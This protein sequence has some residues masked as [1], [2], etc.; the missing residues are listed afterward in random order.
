MK[1]PCNFKL[2]TAM[3]EKKIPQTVF[4]RKWLLVAID[5]AHVARKVN[6]AYV[7]G[8]QLRLRSHITVAMTAT[9]IF[10]GLMVRF[11]SFFL[12]STCP[13]CLNRI[14]G[15]LAGFLAS[16]SLSTTMHWH[17]RWLRRS[18][19]RTGVTSKPLVRLMRW[20]SVTFVA[21]L[22]SK[23]RCCRRAYRGSRCSASGVRT[24]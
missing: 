8:F 13:L 12:L 10:T 20:R 17:E 11:L 9:P 6:K 2:P 3:F 5:E 16:P 4:G 18:P 14:S 7:A 15:T 1:S 23:R 24:M 21:H 19:K 22:R